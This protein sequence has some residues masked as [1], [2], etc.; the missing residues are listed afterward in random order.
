MLLFTNVEDIQNRAAFLGSKVEGE[1][2]PLSIQMPCRFMIYSN[3]N[4]KIGQIGQYLVFNSNTDIE[5][6]DTNPNSEI[7]PIKTKKKA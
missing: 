1:S 5:I 3:G 6:S 2:F 4:R 7:E